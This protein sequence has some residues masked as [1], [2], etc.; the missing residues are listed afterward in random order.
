LANRLVYGKRATPYE[1]LSVFAERMGDTFATEDVLPRLARAIADG[2]GATRAEVWLRVGDRLRLAASSPAT[3]EE[4]V[5]LPL[6]DREVVEIAGA[7]RVVEVRHQG[8]LLGALTLSK[9][10]NDP[11]TLA[12]EKLLTDLASQAGLVLRNVRLTAELRARLEDLRSSRQRLV[13]AQDDERRKLERNLHDGAQQQLVALAV[14]VR[15]ASTLVGT[16]QGKALA[17][18]S[19]VQQELGDALETLR[20]LARGIYPPLLADKGLGAALETQARK[21]AVPVTVEPNGIGR[22]SQEIEAAVYF[23]TLEALNNVAKYAE[24]SSVQVGLADAGGELQF[25]V[26]DDGSGFD[27][28]VTD[29]GTGLQGMAD[30]LDAVGGSLEV[31]SEAGRGTIV[32]GRVPTGD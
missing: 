5:W 7:D 27:T 13:A 1:V 31:R 23:C 12:E 4:A 16:Q 17:M 32:I 11:V 15:L 9:P 28:S 2:T 14:K 19:D 24:A 18:L 26:V 20:D 3:G 21:A 25:R 29:Y 8:E 6:D 10:A 30:R 22:Y